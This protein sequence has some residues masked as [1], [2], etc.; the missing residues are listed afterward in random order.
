MKSQIAEVT[1]RII[2]RSKASR[3]T[4]LDKIERARRTGPFR[5]ELSCGN[6]GARFCSLW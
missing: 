5:G 3:K 6:L 2:E 1:Q 4:Y